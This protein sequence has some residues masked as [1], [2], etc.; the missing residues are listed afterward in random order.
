MS[1]V[2]IEPPEVVQLVDGYVDKEHLDAEKY[3]NRTPL[4]DA[5]VWDL[6]QLAAEIYAR[7]WRDGQNAET[8]RTRAAFARRKVT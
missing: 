5:G 6:H 1:D 2:R 3:D 8:I 7:G 4:D